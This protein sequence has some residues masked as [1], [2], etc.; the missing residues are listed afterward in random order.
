MR[1]KI[2][3]ILHYRDAAKPPIIQM[4]DALPVNIPPSFKTILC[5]CLGHGFRKFRDLLDFFPE[6]CLK[7]MKSLARVFEIE[8]KIQ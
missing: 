8:E 4:C 6:P 2:E 7:V 5:N 1:V 3:K